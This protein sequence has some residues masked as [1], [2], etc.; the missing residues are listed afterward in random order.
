MSNPET[1]KKIY[2]I[3]NRTILI[4]SIFLILVSVFFVT[5]YLQLKSNDPLNSPALEQLYKNLDSDPNNDMLRDQIRSLDLLARKAYFT[6]QW[7]INTGGALLFIAIIILVIA[8]KIKSNLRQ[9][10]PGLIKLEENWD[11]RLMTRKW[12]SLSGVILLSVTILL[13]ILTNREMESA[14]FVVKKQKNLPIPSENEIMKNWPAFRGPFSNAIAH[15]TNI[16][17]TWDGETGE[18][19]LWTV[20]VP[21]IG[22]NSP[23]LWDDRLYM[24]GADEEGQEVFCFNADNGELIW[25]KPVSNVPGTPEELP[26]VTEDTGFAAPTMTTDGNFVFSIFATGDLACFDMDGNQVW[27]KNMGHPDNHYGHS[28]SLIMYEN[29]LLVQF[30]QADVAFVAALDGAT[31][32]EKWKTL[33]DMGLSW[34]SPILAKV[35][36]QW[37]FIVNATPNVVGYDPE[38][39]EE[40]WRMDCLSGEVAPSSA[41]ADGFVYAA[42]DNAI[43]AAIKLGD[44][45]ELAW[46]YEDDLPDVC[47]LVATKEYVFMPSSWGTITCLDAKTGEKYW[48]QEFDDGFY[49]SPVIAGEYVIAMDLEGVTQIFKADKEFELVA[50]N[51]LGMVANSTPVIADG[52]IYFRSTEKLICIGEK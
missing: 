4:T 9:K 1:N 46:E 47:S 52:R 28:S 24:S 37:Q 14:S 26:D 16:P 27:V 48:L 42:N 5:N 6:K 18:N 25:R 8:F 45:P 49:S 12:L 23:I 36:D 51:S 34:S 11:D 2:A 3:L 32:E 43:L 33:R 44:I 40:L 38:T 50:S 39:G 29:L 41:Y 31:G 22:F 10:D 7:Q 20:D 17:L 13:A 21:R 15:Y 35:G 19:I 30:D